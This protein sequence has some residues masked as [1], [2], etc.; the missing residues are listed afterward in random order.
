MQTQSNTTESKDKKTRGE[1]QKS[2]MDKDDF[3]KGYKDT[4]ELDNVG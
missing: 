1:T 3:F 2:K 4:K